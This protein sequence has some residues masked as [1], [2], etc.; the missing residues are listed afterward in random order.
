MAKAA[1]ATRPKT[2]D[3]YQARREIIDRVL[4]RRPESYTRTYTGA[5]PRGQD[6]KAVIPP[7]ADRLPA[8]NLGE[9]VDDRIMAVLGSR[10]RLN[11]GEQ[12]YL[13]ICEAI[14]TGDAG[15][16][17]ATVREVAKRGLSD[18]QQ[19]ALLMT[20]ESLR[21]SAPG[22][23]NDLASVAL[24]EARAAG[25]DQTPRKTRRHVTVAGRD[26]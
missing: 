19:P 18:L 17:R 6:L 16:V 10:V 9:W 13:D 2:T 3:P 21:G 24:G 8:S 1:T 12:C 22:Y 14:R 23:A 5:G 15:T 11:P 7:D 4:A 25:W 26:D 20:L